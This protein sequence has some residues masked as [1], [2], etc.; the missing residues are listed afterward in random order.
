MA[1]IR[2]SLR[3]LLRAPGFTALCVLTLAVGIAAATAIFSIVNGVLLTPLPYPESERLVG[4]WHAAPAFGF[5]KLSQSPGSYLLYRERSRSFEDIALY[6][7]SQVTVTGDGTPERLPAGLVTPSLFPVLRVKPSLGR[8]FVAEE[9]RPG[10]APVVL[11]SDQLWRRRFAADPRALGRPIRI[12]GVPCEIVG[13]MPAGFEFPR[14]ET[15]LWL[16]LAIDPA[17]A[18]FGG[19]GPSSVAR[20]RPGITP[21][22]AQTELDRLLASLRSAP[23]PATRGMIRGGLQARVLPLHEDVVGDVGRTLWILL[24]AVGFILLIAC[25]NVSN[26]LIVRGEGRRRETA[27][28]TALGASQRQVVGSVLLESLLLAG[29]AGGL[30]LLLAAGG[31]RLLLKL[32]SLD[33]PRLKEIGI[34]GRVLLFTAAVAVLSTLLAGLFPALRSLLKGDLALELKTGGTRT[35]SSHAQQRMRRLLVGLQVGLALVLLTG[36]GLMLRSFLRLSQLDPGFAT[37]DVLT[38]QLNLSKQDFPNDVAAAGFLDSVVERLRGLPGV[39][40]AGVASTLPLSGSDQSTGHVIQDQPLPPGSP[41]PGFWF[42]Y[43]GEGYFEALGIPLLAG[44]TLTRADQETRTRVAVVNQALARHFWPRGDALGKRLRPAAAKEG[45]SEPWYTIVG[46][47]GDVRNRDLTMAPDE[48]VYYPLLGQGDDA[49]TVRQANVVMRTRVAPESLAS[50]VRSAVG[51]VNPN[52]PVS[53]VRSMEQVLRRS[54]ARMIYS[55]LMFVLATAVAMVL[56]AVGIYSFVSY[57]VSQRTAELGV[58]TALGARARD[59]RWLILRESLAIGL[60]GALV[61]LLG[62]LALTQWL[63][64]LLFEISPFDPLTFI[65]MPLLLLALVLLSSALPAERAARVDPVKALQFS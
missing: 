40:S 5:D 62:S 21:A 34:D 20:L 4:L 45:G 22:A 57:V 6:R 30:G 65:L 25:A 19:F 38:F 18:E 11:L 15:E 55:V 49:W 14:P 3:G 17:K 33:L 10:A 23:D 9:G 42:G 8:P 59:L 26:L 29:A 47:V 13:V 35:T 1:L 46:I 51:S 32:G 24:G 44:R 43:A 37:Q 28:H 31:L 7:S 50:E 64:S 2:R 52:V 63:G 56:A 16:P 39:R 53:G 48:M 60:A 41:P 12:D 27:I 54:Q 36:S 61:G 58:R